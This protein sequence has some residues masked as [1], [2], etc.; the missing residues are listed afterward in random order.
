MVVYYTLDARLRRIRRLIQDVLH[1]TGH[2][3]IH[4]QLVFP[5]IVRRVDEVWAIWGTIRHAIVHCV[6]EWLV[7]MQ[8]WQSFR[9]MAVESN[10]GQS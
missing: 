4:H 10:E 8:K 1:G 5:I 6:E 9:T 2:G 3:E 7:F